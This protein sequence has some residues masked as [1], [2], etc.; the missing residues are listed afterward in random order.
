M[1]TPRDRAQL[2]CERADECIRLADIVGND[3]LRNGYIRVAKH[4]LL[5]A[6]AELQQLMQKLPTVITPKQ[7]TQP[8]RR[9]Y[10]P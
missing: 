3:P 4:Y 2:Y 8:Q 10:R 9:L 6:Q 1:S 7:P 5:L